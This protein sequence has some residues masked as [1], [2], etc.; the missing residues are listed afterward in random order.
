MIMKV[1]VGETDDPY[2]ITLLNSLLSGLAKNKAADGIWIIHIDNWFDDKWLRFS[3]I[4]S[5]HFQFPAYM[6]RNDAALD[7]FFQDKVTFPP[8]APKRVIAQWSFARVG[9]KFVEVPSQVPH[10]SERHRSK[11]NLQRRVQDFSQSGCF[12]WYSGNTV[13]NGRGSVMVYIVVAGQVQCWFASF[14]RQ[15]DWKLQATNGISREDVE[16]LLSTAT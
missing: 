1:P 9:E 3:G 10:R 13:A 6:N 11:A 12:V 5:V 16:E 2:F 4:G 14:K 7:E 8:F 15:Q